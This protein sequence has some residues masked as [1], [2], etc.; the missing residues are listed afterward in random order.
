[1]K[2]PR[3]LGGEE[4]VRRLEE[5][6]F[7]RVRQSGSHILLKHAPSG[8]TITIPAHRPLKVGTLSSIFRDICTVTELSRSEVLEQISR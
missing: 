8:E 6:G 1:L 4:L 3:D 5:L 2:L 7:A